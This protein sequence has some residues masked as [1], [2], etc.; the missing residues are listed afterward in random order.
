MLRCNHRVTVGVL[1]LLLISCSI[2]K[3][4]DV[5]SLTELKSLTL[6]SF[7]IVQH[8]QAGN[9]S[10]F[11]SLKYDSVVS[12]T[13]AG[14]G[15]HISRVKAFTL[16]AFGNPKMKLKSGTTA[17]TEITIGYRDNGMPNAFVVSKGD[18]VVEVYKFFYN[19]SSPNQLIK[20]VVDIDPIDNLPE[21][22]HIKDTIIYTSGISY[23][24]SIIRHSPDPT[25]AGTFTACQNCGSGSSA[26]TINQYS[27]QGQ[28]SYQV[29]FNSA[30]NCSSN[31][32][33]P[34]PCGGINRTGSTG[35]GQNGNQ[36][37][38]TFINNFTFSKTIQ[39]QLT[40]ASNVDAY[41][42][43]PIMIVKDGITHGDFFFWFYSVDW[44]Q[45]TNNSL[46]NDDLVKININYGH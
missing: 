33:Y 35:G 16:P 28:S 20:F 3:D 19:S 14:T 44:F 40:S 30:G 36:N 42:F 41:F 45:T 10:A 17:A 29:N 6:K 22:L 12:R 23:P 25:V 4:S 43:H 1:L 46:N 34:Y 2:V 8:S 37:Q 26:Q 18:S 7:E 27:F 38:L 5:T 11:A 32:Y 24:S 39:T 9:S 15:A 13:S 31:T 21:L